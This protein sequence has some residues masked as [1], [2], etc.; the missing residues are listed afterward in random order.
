ME[1]SMYTSYAFNCGFKSPV[2]AFRHFYDRG[3]KYG[4]ILDCELKEYPLNDYCSYLR[5]AGI[6]PDAV[7]SIRNIASFDKEKRT[8]C[9]SEVKGLID[10]ME[11]Q[12]IPFLMLAPSVEIPQNREEYQ[13]LRELLVESFA[14]ITQYSDGAITVAIENQSI[15]SR[16]D[17]RIED[18]RYILDCLPNLGF[19]LDTG[20]FFCVEDDA[21]K[22]CDVLSDRLL[23]I[24]AKDWQ[25]DKFGSFVR[26]N[27]PRFEGVALGKGM[28]PLKDIMAKLRSTSH[29]GKAV[30]E[31]NARNVTL[32]MIDESIDFLR[33]EI[34]V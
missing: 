26:E 32:D 6:V 20:N 25:L 3:V 1:I 2:D 10:D 9:L 12:N 27:I 22:A 14:H 4:D 15:P 30:V 18:I 34:N 24:H 17:S 31:I 13:K 8:Q 28:I 21:V 33:N 19:V 5:E 23:R 7:V 11:K 16:P 29:Q